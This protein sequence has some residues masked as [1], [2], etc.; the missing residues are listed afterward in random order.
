MVV[1][2]VI[3]FLERARVICENDGRL[4][5]GVDRRISVTLLPVTDLSRFSRETVQLNCQS[6][7]IAAAIRQNF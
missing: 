5:A 6:E 1:M 7:M 4:S 3:W 2:V